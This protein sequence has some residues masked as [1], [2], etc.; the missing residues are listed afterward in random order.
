MPKTHEPF[1]SSSSKR[2]VL[3]VDDEQINRDLLGFMLDGTY[4]CLY[5]ANGLE[6]LRAIRKYRDTLS[7]VF[8]DLNMP[9]IHGLDL[10]KIMKSDPSLR[11]VP[12]MVITSE[13]NAEV[14]SLQLGAMDFIPK[15]YPQ[16]EIIL[17]R[18]RRII[19]LSEDRQI[20][21][22][23]ERDSLT[24]L[25][26]RDYFFGYSHQLDLFRKD[27]PMDAILVDINHFHM[28]NERFGRS[29]GDEILRRVAEKLGES[30][31]ANG[32]IICRRDAD[33]FLIYCPH[34]MDYEAAVKSAS[35]HL[36]EDPLMPS[37]QV[38]LRMGVYENVDKSLDL[39]R[40]FDRAKLAANTLR[41]NC[42]KSVAFYT[43]EMHQKEIFDAQL[44]DDFYPALMQKQFKVY[45]QPK[46]DISQRRPFI[47]SAEALVRW[48]HPTLGLIMP[49]SFI[50]L[51]EENGLI[52][53]L[54][55]FV[56]RETA[57]QIARWKRQ[58]GFAIPVSVNISRVD[59]YD[60]ELTTFFQSILKQYGLQSH[61]LRLEITESA[62]NDIADLIIQTVGQLRSMGF[63]IEMDDFGTGYSSLG[64]ISNLPI[65]A[66]KLDMMF[67]HN[68]LRGDLDARMLKLVRDI[69]NY[70][71]VPVI[72]EGVETL[73]QAQALKDAGCD[74][75]Q[76]FYFSKPVPA[77]AFAEL[78]RTSSLPAGSDAEQ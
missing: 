39:E 48:Q 10:L 1:R 35:I 72:A 52:P 27:Q 21:R 57:A 15:P 54:D 22:F 68:A 46:Y 4:D 44:V 66:L 6:A 69:A 2:L 78:A 23:T 29:F 77:E 64:M 3:I 38:H 42:V 41:G 70:L 26:N 71:S 49:G 7:L 17:A 20:I 60:P 55:R 47:A 53:Q 16:P 75:L 11:Q 40:R 34:G 5:A 8:L 63:C 43:E 25:F 59:I 13:N 9:E 45:Y 76:G 56:W 37:G 61:E 24:R 58:F 50:P 62:Y 19:E 12:V 32:G 73:E 67:V 33:V 74:M 28:L 30:V 65:D 31:E 36:G 14:E 18:A 51:F